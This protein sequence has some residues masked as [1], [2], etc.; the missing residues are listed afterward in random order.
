MMTVSRKATIASLI[1]A[2]DPR[3]APV[4]KEIRGICRARIAAA[5]T[6]LPPQIERM[7]TSA[8]AVRIEPR[9][10]SATESH[11]RV[12]HR[13]RR[14]RPLDDADV[15]SLLL[16]GVLRMKIFAIH[17]HNN[18]DPWTD[19]PAWALELRFMLGII[20]E[21][22][23]KLM[24]AIDDLAAAVAAEDTVIDSAVVLLQGIPALIAAAGTD[25]AALTKL[26]ADITA[27]TTTL[28]AAVLARTPTPAAAAAPVTPAAANA[29]ATAAV[30]SA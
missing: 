4:Q 25:P 23:E 12:C 15:L 6:S 27:K 19:A 22:Q 7:A 24:A 11:E 30:A 2:A 21:D 29:A 3:C 1:H 9:A 8:T 17:L 20:I 14:A 18:Q 10:P 5:K 16:A 13:D 28:S 26:Q